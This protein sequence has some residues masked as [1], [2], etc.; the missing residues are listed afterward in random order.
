MKIEL[1]SVHPGMIFFVR[2]YSAK[3]VD[4]CSMVA[5]F[6]NIEAPDDTYLVICDVKDE[7]QKIIS[8]W[9]YDR[10]QWLPYQPEYHNPNRLAP[11]PKPVE[12]PPVIDI[13]DVIDPFSTDFV[14]ETTTEEEPRD[15]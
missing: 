6:R 13:T 3:G 8:S 2:V 11:Q 15:Q 1:P 5:D 9:G 12:L 7:A 4:A 14:E 10:T